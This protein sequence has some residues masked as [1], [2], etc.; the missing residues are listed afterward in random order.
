MFDM[1]DETIVRR[2][3]VIVGGGNAGLIIAL[4]LRRAFPKYEITIVK[5]DEIGT[6]GVGEG[7]TEHWRGYMDFLKIQ[8]SEL[9]T[10]TLGTHKRGIRFEG[11]TTGIP[12]Y[13]HAVSGLGNDSPRVLEV[14]AVYAAL[15]ARGELL[16]D[17]TSH[18]GFKENLVPAIDPHRSVNQFHFDTHKLNEFFVRKCQKRNIRFVEGKVVDV[19]LSDSEWIESIRIEGR[20]DLVEADFWI[21]ASGFNRVLMSHLPGSKWNSFSKYLLTDSAIAFRT[22]SD[23]SGE[24]RPY[25]RAIAMDNGWSWEIPTQAARGMGYVYSS[26]FCS[27]EQAVT[28][29]EDLLHSDIGDYRHFQFD[30]GYLDKVWIGNCVAVG[31][32]GSFVE[33]LEATSIGATIQQSYALVGLLA[34]FR[35][36]N[37]YSIKEYNRMFEGMMLNIRDMIRLHYVSDREDTPFWAAQKQ[38]PIPESL[39]HLLGVWS[40][41]V[42]EGTDLQGPWYLFKTPHFYHVAQ[43]QGV[44]NPQ[45]GSDAIAALGLEERID[46]FLWMMKERKTSRPLKD[47]A[48][49]LKE[50]QQS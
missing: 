41:R 17:A 40:E 47:H 24:I 2:R 11:W 29:M 27:E 5:S 38:T 23:P 44:L 16:S 8:T 18:H 9:L 6:I 26:E 48:Q 43:G 21:D 10:A 30:P 46:N 33:P 25:T 35:K 39:E 34:P 50:L 15:L 3:V 1:D 37:T 45:S 13:F 36:G 14:N 49:T 31:L 19:E 42:P 4:L 12:E 28:E 7:S 22:E 20:D 32:A